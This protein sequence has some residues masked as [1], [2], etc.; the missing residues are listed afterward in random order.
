MSSSAIGHCA[1][2]TTTTA[3]TLDV[4]T[5]FRFSHTRRALLTF[6]AALASLLKTALHVTDTDNNTDILGVSGDF[7]VQLATRI[8]S[9]NRSLVSDM[10]ARIL[11]RMSVSVSV[12][13]NAGF[14]IERSVRRGDVDCPYT[15]TV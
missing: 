2:L 1:L 5:A 15:I 13:W 6:F 9:E 7:L 12:S 4:S 8:T 10:S 14:T 11:T 3:P